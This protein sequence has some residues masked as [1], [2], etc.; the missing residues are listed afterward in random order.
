LFTK[1]PKKKVISIFDSL[2]SQNVVYWGETI[3]SRHNLGKY[4]TG[5]KVFAALV[6][7]AHMLNITINW[8]PSRDHFCF[9]SNISGFPLLPHLLLQVCFFLGIE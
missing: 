2:M 7:S 6:E 4:G 8:E 9:C 5:A 3:L 1:C